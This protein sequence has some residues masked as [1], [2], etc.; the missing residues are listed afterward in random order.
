[1]DVVR[2][3]PDILAL[4]SQLRAEGWQP[5]AWRRERSRPRWLRRQ[6]SPPERTL[7][8]L[9]ALQT[10]LESGVPL[11]TGLSLLGQQFGDPALG[12]LSVSV[13]K[14]VSGGST[15]S[16]ALALEADTIPETVRWLVRSGES[17]G[18][19]PESMAEARRLWARSLDFRRKIR[20]AA[21]YPLTTL[22]L[23]MVV[24]AVLVPWI[25]PTFEAI[26]RDLKTPLPLPTRL[27]LGAWHG[28]SRNGVWLAP[29]ALGGCLGT[30]RLAQTPRGKA[31][32]QALLERLPGWAPWL[33][34]ASLANT[35]AA[36][37]G[38]LESGVP[39]VEALRVTGSL[40]AHRG[41]R[42]AMV[43]TAAAVSSGHRLSEH[44][45]REKVFPPLL[46][47]MVAVGESTGS[48]PDVLRRYAAFA[49]QSVDQRLQKAAAMFEPAMVAVVG[50]VVG[51]VLVA[52]YL[53]IITLPETLLRNG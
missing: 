44:W 34:D 5:L 24:L 7:A 35:L 6:K 14:A 32:L 53:P 41:V 49:D 39:M 28:F 30:L 45:S 16:A 15:L 20:G 36:L 12:V 22:A 19:L 13:A 51:G 43:G 33:R 3:A 11:T 52:L 18:R 17:A 48:L 9:A 8:W 4:L 42:D 21:T 25:V 10:M 50:L 31:G 23:A 46:C 2:I 26:Y 38:L 27:L 37:A 47:G 40:S 1:M 29:L